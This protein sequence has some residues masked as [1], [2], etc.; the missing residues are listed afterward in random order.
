MDS[1]ELMFSMLML[2]II[3]GVGVCMIVGIAVV[4]MIWIMGGIWMFSV[5]FDSYLEKRRRYAIDSCNLF[6]TLPIDSIAITFAFL[7]SLVF[8]VLSLPT[9]IFYTLPPMSIMFGGATIFHFR[10]SL[11]NFARPERQ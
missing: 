3:A 4:F 1:S 8:M 11:L 5:V 10:S 7:V 6:I 9:A 2:P